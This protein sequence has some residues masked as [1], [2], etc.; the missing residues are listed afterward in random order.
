MAHLQIKKASYHA[1]KDE[2]L[3]PL[4]LDLQCQGITAIL[5]PNGAGKSLF[6][7]LCHGML[8]NHKGVVLWDNVPAAQS[9][10]RRGFMFQHPAILRRS[11]YA[12]V[13]F[14]LSAHGVPRVEHP[15]RLEEVLKQ[16]RLSHKAKTPAAALSGGEI[17]RMGLARALATRPEVI[18]MDEPAAG[19][20]PAS[21]AALEQMVGEIVASGTG[22]LMVSHD[23]PQ[24]RRLAD[25]VLFF[26]AGCLAENAPS[27]QFFT[28]PET[29]AAKA[30]LEG[31]L[32]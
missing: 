28:G 7:H 5:G 6:L 12:N 30:Y 1:E 8:D 10:D 27:E 17:R 32:L 31:R 16:A 15:K 9:R 29:E 22:I 13:E 21:S 2:L 24:A 25:H 26:D 18:L 4:T 11:V 19:L 3:K 20:D 14:A 23:L